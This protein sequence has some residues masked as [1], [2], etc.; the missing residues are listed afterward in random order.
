MNTLSLFIPTLYLYILMQSLLERPVHLWLYIPCRQSF[1]I[2]FSFNTEWSVLHQSMG[3]S[4][5]RPAEQSPLGGIPPQHFHGEYCSPK[6]QYSDL[7]QR[8]AFPQH[9]SNKIAY[10]STPVSRETRQRIF[11]LKLSVSFGRDS[12]PVVGFGSK[13]D[14]CDRILLTNN[15]NLYLWNIS[16]GDL[17]ERGTLSSNTKLPQCKDGDTLHCTLDMGSCTV[18]FTVYRRGR[19]SVIQELELPGLP[20]KLWPLVGVLRTG[21]TPV[22]FH[23]LWFDQAEGSMD[24]MQDLSTKVRFDDQTV[25]GHLD[26]SKNGKVVSRG[27]TVQ[28]NSCV[29]INQVMTSGV[30]YWRLRVI[31][32]FGASLC[33]GIAQVPFE[34]SPVYLN[35]PL[36]HIY[37]HDRIMVWRS[38]RGLLYDNGVQ[39]DLTLEPIG[40]QHNSTVDIALRVDFST[41]TLEI[42][43]N[44]K[45]LGVAFRNVSGPVQPILGFYAGYEKRV[46]LLEYHTSQSDPIPPIVH[47]LHTRSVEGKGIKEIMPVADTR[48][49][50]PSFDPDAKYGEIQISDDHMTVYRNKNQVGNAYCLLNMDCMSGLYHWAFIVE[51]DQGASSCTGVAKQPIDMSGVAN[52]YECKQM[53][54]Y[55]SF[56]GM[57]YHNGR[58]LPKR[59]EESWMSGSLV[60]LTLDIEGNEGVLQYTI[61]GQD[62]GV[63]FGSIQ[64]P[65]T[66]LVG[67]YAGMEKRITLIHFSHK[68]KVPKLSPTV[69]YPGLNDVSSTAST[70]SQDALP[71]LA[72]HS[73]ADQYYGECMMCG[74]ENKNVIAIPCRHAVLC[75]DHLHIGN[76]CLICQEKIQGVW[77]ILLD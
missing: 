34:L 7:N 42:L 14:E 37:R 48:T 25:S 60:E 17:I 41:R 62:Q 20:E 8:A 68:E 29:L 58:E 36:K 33:V 30:H 40:W 10:L 67:F 54:L 46:E 13:L 59:F 57:L 65:V 27:S 24:H 1:S 75:A 19:E 69:K 49:V 71:I 3:N 51:M 32:D 45:S 77:N 4:T 5:S 6:V 74:S 18:A 11:I 43:R 76:D 16:T 64:P 15:H 72:T 52:I 61:N 50:A 39:Q 66:P 31:C 12:F 44:E 56:Q 26:I 35:D 63:A 28:G 55:R 2:T 73:D 21:Q 47:E 53:Y 22:V 70:A 38:Y 23:L 9:S